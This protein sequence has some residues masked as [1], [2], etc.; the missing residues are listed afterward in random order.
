[1]LQR[2][3]AILILVVL[4]FNIT[5]RHPAFKFKQWRIR[6]ELS[7]RI[8]KAFHG[9]DIQIVT[10][11]KNSTALEWI[12]TGKEFRYNDK[13][14]DVVRAEQNDSTINYYCISD[15]DESQLLSHYE[16]FI[17]EQQSTGATA[18]GKSSLSILKIFFSLFYIPKQELA[19]RLQNSLSQP[20][21][22]F[23]QCFYYD[24]FT[25]ITVPPPKSIM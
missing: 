18:P 6:K 17:H 15:E 10:V 22:E 25:S 2:V 19:D 20:Q 3:T 24:D 1:M 23:Y 9:D 7:A 12:R 13:L 4:L 5:G 16:R 11:A 21:G 14:Y 8:E